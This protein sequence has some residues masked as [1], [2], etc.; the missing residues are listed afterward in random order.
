MPSPIKISSEAPMNNCDLRTRW[1]RCALAVTA[2]IGIAFQSHAQSPSLFTAEQAKRGQAA[3]EEN[4][5]RCHG[6]SLE[7]AQFGPP[8]I[9]QDFIDRWAGQPVGALYTFMRTSMP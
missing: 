6:T 9:S 2:W 5:S 4:C 3:Y 8:L 7:G 1:V